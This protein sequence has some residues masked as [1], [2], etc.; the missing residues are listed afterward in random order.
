MTNT[1]VIERM[2]VCALFET[3]PNVVN[4]VHWRIN[5]D[6]NS[7]TASVYGTRAIPYDNANP[8]TPFEDLTQDQ[9]ITWVKNIMGKEGIAEIEA[10]I[11]YLL[12]NQRN[13]VVYVLPSPWDH[14]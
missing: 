3:K 14:S 5:A 4:N 6:D 10:R 12:E 9:V 1:W 11:A 7:Y 8:F 2:D 13:P